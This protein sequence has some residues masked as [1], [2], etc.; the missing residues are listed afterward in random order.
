M[1]GATEAKIP[2]ETE[3]E[4][5]LHGLLG[6]SPL[7]ADALIEAIDLGR[8]SGE[9]YPMTV[10]QHGVSCGCLYAWAEFWS[11]LKILDTTQKATALEFFVADVLP[12]ETHLT[13]GRLK[14]I[15]ERCL[16][17]RKTQRKGGA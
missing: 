16:L 4:K 14:A 12:G 1:R 10:N 11:G 7:I 5:E 13:N 2:M 17:R 15:R 3:A 9:D 6:K 8:V